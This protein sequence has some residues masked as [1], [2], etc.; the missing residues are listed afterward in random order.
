MTAT[1]ATPIPERLTEIQ[2]LPLLAGLHDDEQFGKEMCV[3]EAVAYV[4][5]E[6]HSD[7]PACACPVIAD[8][9]RCWN[10]RLGEGERANADRDRL[11]KPLVARLVGSR[12]TP[13]VEAKRRTILRE[14][15]RTAP[16]ADYLE[17]A[18]LSEHADAVRANP[19]DYKTIRA[20]RDAAWEI[21]REQRAALRAKVTEAVKTKLG[22][23]AAAAA[24]AAVAVAAA[25][26]AAVADAAVAAV[27]AAV[28]AVA[29]AAVADAAVAADAVAAAAA[30]ADAADAVA[31]AAA[32]ADAA[33]AFG[34]GTPG[35]WKVRAA[36]YDAVREK[37]DAVVQADDRLRSLRSRNEEGLLA[38]I[39]RM[40]AVTHETLAS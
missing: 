10:D 23:A 21:R 20:A 12:S 1:A 38:T 9:L 31:A 17:I 2:N 40:L 13:D 7:H 33:A 25:A 8:V 14:W 15:V 34:Y 30:A 11:L 3:M 28:A 37:Y 29:D 22:A 32:A 5:G 4:A 24:A 35:Y 6:P 18:G 19:L 36:V 16:L 27:A 26:D 39:D